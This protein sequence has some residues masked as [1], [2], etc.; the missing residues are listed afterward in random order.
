MDIKVKSVRV[1]EEK[2]SRNLA[3]TWN[4]TQFTKDDFMIQLVF[5]EAFYISSFSES[6]IVEIT[7][8]D[9]S[10]FFDF[11]GQPITNGTVIARELPPQL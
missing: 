5:E 9:T 7:F 3:F 8:V 10:L 6:D 4:V 1:D 2:E 11:A